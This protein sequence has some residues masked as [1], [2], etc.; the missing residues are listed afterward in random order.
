MFISLS[1]DVYV[2]VMS[3]FGLYLMF[4]QIDFLMIRM[5]ADCIVTMFTTWEWMKNKKVD[6]VILSHHF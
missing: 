5:V 2:H 4:S 1:Y 3:I 6:K